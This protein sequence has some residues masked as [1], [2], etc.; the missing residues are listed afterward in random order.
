MY[1]FHHVISSWHDH[2]L[3]IQPSYL[4][5]TIWSQ[6]CSFSLSWRFCEFSHFLTW[7]CS[8]YTHYFH[9]PWI[10]PT[11]SS[12]LPKV[13]VLTF[14]FFF[15]NE[16]KKKACLSL[17]LLEFKVYKMCTVWGPKSSKIG[18]LQ[19]NRE[20]LIYFEFILLRIN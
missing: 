20:L 4:W 7:C 19:K 6:S 12:T 16:T 11:T 14:F 17:S 10:S 5:P 3:L 8:L 18:R 13:H 2:N 1:T 9:L 15:F